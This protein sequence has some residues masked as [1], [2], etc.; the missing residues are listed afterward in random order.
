MQNRRDHA[1]LIMNRVDA[2]IAVVNTRGAFLLAFNT[3]LFGGIVS[4]YGDVLGLVSDPEAIKYLKIC[5]MTLLLLSLV[6]TTFTMN[7]VYPFLSAGN[8]VKGKYHSLIFFKSVAQFKDADA[9][10]DKWKEI[11]DDEAEEDIIRQSF[12]LA[13]GLNKKYKTLSWAIRFVYAQV[14]V[15]FITLIIISVS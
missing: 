14:F 13:Q 2:Y 7:A 11:T 10:L 5:L 6:T 15:L 1:K 12:H 9:Y 4:N 3:F 8:P